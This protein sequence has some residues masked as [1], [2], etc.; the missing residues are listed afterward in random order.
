MYMSQVILFPREG[1]IQ[2]IEAYGRGYQDC[3]A[4]KAYPIAQ[5]LEHGY[6][7][8]WQDANEDMEE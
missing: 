1:D 5:R 7:D 6:S 8:G 4:R 2:Y 3:L